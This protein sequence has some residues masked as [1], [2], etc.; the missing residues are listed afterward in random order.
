MGLL[1]PKPVAFDFDSVALLQYFIAGE[2][3]NERWIPMFKE[4]GWIDDEGQ[5]TMSG[6]KHYNEGWVGESTEYHN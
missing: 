4:F 1:T 2:A 5:L 3:W 6:I